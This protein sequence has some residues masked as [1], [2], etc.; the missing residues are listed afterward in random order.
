MK[1]TG[2]ILASAIAIAL[3]GLTAIAAAAPGGNSGAIWTTRDDCGAEKQDVNLY[4]RGETV[5]INGA[6]FKPG[7]YGWEIVGQPGGASCDPRATV[8]SGDVTVDASGAFC[9]AAYVVADDDCGEYKVNVGN[10]GDNYRVDV[11]ESPKPD[12]DPDPKPDP[13]PTPAPG[14]QIIKTVNGEDANDFPGPQVD[15]GST[16]VW[17][18]KIS[19][20]GNV[21]LSNI[22]ITDDQGVTPVYQSG[23]VNNNRLLDAGEVWI[24][25]ASGSAIIGP[26]KNVGTVSARYDRDKIKDSDS[27]CYLGIATSG[28]IDGTFEAD[29]EPMANKI[30]QLDAE[31]SNTLRTRTDKN[32]Y[33][34]F[35]NV[36]RGVEYTVSVSGFDDLTREVTLQDG[37]ACTAVN[38]L[39]SGGHKPVLA[40]YQTWYS[41]ARAESSLRYWVPNNLGGVIDTAKVGRYDSY[42]QNILEY[43]ILQAWAANVDAMVVDWYGEESFEDGPTHAMLNIVERLHNNYQAVGFN[44][45]IIL[46]YNEQAQGDLETNLKHL[47]ET[48]LNHP[49]YYGVFE[50]RPR[51]IFVLAED[52]SFAEDFIAKARVLLPQDVLIVL[53]YKEE[54][55]DLAGKV[56]GF[57]P[58]ITEASREW[59]SDGRA[60]GELYLSQFYNALEKLHPSFG[61]G[62]TWPGYD[63]RAWVQGKDLYVDRQ[64]SLVYLKTWALAEKNQPDYVMIQSWNSFN[65][66][67]QIEPSDEYG[68]KFLVLSRDLAAQWK[69]SAGRYVN[70]IGLTVPE[71][72]LYA[73][74]RG[75]DEAGIEEALREFF[76]GNYERALA[77][78]DAGVTASSG[79]YYLAGKDQPLAS[80][81]VAFSLEQNHPNPFNPQTTIRYSLAEPVRVTLKVYD[82]NGR[83]VATLADGM[84]ESGSHQAV[85]NAIAEPSGTYIYHLRAGAYSAVKRMALVK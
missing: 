23:D 72:L 59:N 47:G 76:D 45:D 56:D 39:A 36:L 10:K 14:I 32:G 3:L 73:R 82:I 55:K 17:Q 75:M 31:G 61:V 35:E 53:N 41:D 29:G 11:K 19:N 68:Y 80:Q 77:I 16:V 12:P 13:D 70:N 6:N 40:W 42:D 18:Y 43:H 50:K 8:A 1:K 85:W 83:Q 48:I 44:F 21:P 46:S 28:C 24:Y 9:F 33:F 62:A 71:H 66:S 74:G 4:Q 5:Y 34:T 63:D 20:T 22:K 58:Y 25:S 30:I 7:V 78:L 26:Y 2:R 79:E 15:A 54:F 81:P 38:L 67:T 49:G 57:Y 37:S 84:Q 69:W 51:P 60:W 27:A 64:D 65:Q 52:H